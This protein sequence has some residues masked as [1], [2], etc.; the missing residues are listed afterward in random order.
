MIWTITKPTKN[1]IIHFQFEYTCV[2]LTDHRSGITL[3]IGEMK[4]FIEQ[5]FLL[6]SIKWLTDWMPDSHFVMKLFS[7][8]YFC[9]DEHSFSIYSLVFDRWS[10]RPVLFACGWTRLDKT[11]LFSMNWSQLNSN[12]CSWMHITYRKCFRLVDVN[13]EINQCSGD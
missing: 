7:W 6:T 9:L 8:L 11:T 12:N 1:T 10:L 13:S 4:I 2:P 3:K 5:S